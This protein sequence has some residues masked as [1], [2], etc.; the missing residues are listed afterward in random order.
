MHTAAASAAAVVVVVG[1]R[2]REINELHCLPA[3]QYNN[4]SLIILPNRFCL[5]RILK[6]QFYTACKVQKLTL[7]MQNVL[8]Y[9]RK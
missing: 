2:V 7:H 5:S 3:R 8:Q 9:E 6:R 1:M 4:Y